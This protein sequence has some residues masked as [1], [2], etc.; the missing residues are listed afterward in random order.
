MASNAVASAITAGFQLL[1]KSIDA[2][3]K[4]AEGSEKRKMKKAIE[5]GEQMALAIL[6]K[7]IDNNDLDKLAERFFKYNN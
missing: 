1:S 3:S 2:F 4:W 6:N 7:D 5:I